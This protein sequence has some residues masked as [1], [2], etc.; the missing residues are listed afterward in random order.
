MLKAVLIDDEAKSRENLK[1][2]LQDFCKNVEVSAMAQNVNEGIEIIE[3]FKPDIVFLDIQMQK[4]TGFDLLKKIGKINFEIIFTTAHS[5]YAIDAIKFAAIDYLL[6]PIDISDLKQAIARVENKRSKN[7]F[8]EQFEALLHNFRAESNESYKLAIPTSDGLIFIS[9]K[10]IVY[11]EAVSNYTKIHMKDNKTHMV[12]KTLK[13]YENM[14]S[15]HH[16][17]RV[18]HAYLINTKEIKKYVRGD[19]GYVIMNNDA[20]IDVSKRKKEAFLKKIDAFA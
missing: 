1:I 15:N 13:D 7:D 5:E 14:L 11:C 10:D 4:E 6:K 20:C 3:A 17:F 16:F 8:K 9:I 18:H 2:L 19:G 12:S